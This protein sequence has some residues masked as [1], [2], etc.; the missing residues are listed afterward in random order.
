M[1]VSRIDSNGRARDARPD[2]TLPGPRG[3]HDASRAAGK[4]IRRAGRGRGLLLGASLLLAPSLL[5]AGPGTDPRQ[6]MVEL[7]GEPAVEAWIRSRAEGPRSAL[8]ASAASTRV[9][10]LRVEQARVEELLSAPAIGARVQYRVTRAFNGIAIF[11]EPSRVEAIRALPGVKSVKPLVLHAPA[12]STSVPHL[13]VPQGVWR[14]LGNA[15]EDVKV[16]VIDSGLDYLHAMF[17]GTGRESDYK[18]NDRTKINDG[19]FPTARVVGGWDFAGDD[20]GSGGA[21]KP[22]PDPMDCGGH[23]T[24]VAGSVG[25]SGVLAD[26]SAYAGPFDASVP[27]ASMRIGP[28]VAPRAKLYA[29]RVFGCSGST[30][31]T[32]QAIDWAMDPNDDGD[33]SD[34]LDVLNLTPGSEFGSKDDSTAIA[35]DN[36]A[37]AGIV[38]V[39]SAGNSGDT[40]FVTGSPA[41]A[42]TAISVAA[43]V[44]AGVTASFVAVLAPSSIEGRVRPGPRSSGTPRPRAGRSDLS[45]R[46]SRRGSA[47]PSRTAPSWRGRS[48]SST[49]GAARSTGR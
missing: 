40:Y 24:H 22:D 43:S 20:Y 37:R 26:G 29:L 13:G 46:R 32:T 17:G 31:L 15:G 30:G 28:G 49:G 47:A 48:P 42:D 14:A 5:A 11:A 34:H 1:L 36:A 45:S 27:F 44:D 12:N 18:A 21:A 19:F 16:G 39:C 33:F 2:A 6:W 10:E 8:A 4:R 3:A 7:E 9:A 38:V 25:G 41:A 35:A 23:G